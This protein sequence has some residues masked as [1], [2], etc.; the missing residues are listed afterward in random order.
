MWLSRFT[1]GRNLVIPEGDEDKAFVAVGLL[2]FAF[3][4][5]VLLLATHT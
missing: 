1:S 3:C 2:V 4:K 5:L